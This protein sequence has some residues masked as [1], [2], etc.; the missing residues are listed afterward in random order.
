VKPYIIFNPTA[1][2]VT[3]A[4][5][6]LAALK[7]LRPTAVLIT[8][9]SGD[10]EKWS[11][12]SVRAGCEYIVAAGGDGTLNEIVNGIARARHRPRIGILPLGT[13]NDFA[14]TLDLPFSLEENIDILRASKTRAIDIVRVQSDRARYFVNVSAGGF[15][16]MVRDK[17]T[18]KIKRNW[19]PL[20]YIRGAA[21]A[22]PKLHAYKTR[23][24]LDEREELSAALYN[25]V[26]A[27]GRFV[28]AGLPIAPD[29]DPADGFLDIILIPKRNGPEMALL[30]AEIILGRHFSSGAIIFRRAKKITVR[31]RPSMWFNVDGELVGRA[32]A[33]FQI[34]PRALN[35][36][37]KR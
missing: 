6:T 24:V 8:K 30:A 16:G 7:R 34:L 14:R 1:G 26:I 31:S 37:V 2:S 10:A 12:Q 5:R 23:I 33:V 3:N 22:L 36:V 11:R 25:V 32:P 35:F 19:G 15:S 29:A 20:A 27:N 17:I 4:G 28:A 21:A 18:P 13:G 9:K